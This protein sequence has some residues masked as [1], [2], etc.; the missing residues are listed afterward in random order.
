M[1]RINYVKVSGS[2]LENEVL[3]KG[4]GYSKIRCGGVCSKHSCNYFIL[5]SSAE[6]TVYG[7]EVVGDVIYVDDTVW[8]DSSRIGKYQ[9]YNS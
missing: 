2:R 3:Y 8:M 9:K 4:E 7:H 1:K 5:S 6:C